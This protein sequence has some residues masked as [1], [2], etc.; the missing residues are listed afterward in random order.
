[1]S[2]LTR[3]IGAAILLGVQGTPLRRPVETR[4]SLGPPVEGPP[5]GRCTCG[6]EMLPAETVNEQDP[7]ASLAACGVV[8]CPNCGMV[9]TAPDIRP[10]VVAALRRG[11]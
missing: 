11:I 8:R 9:G 10:D 6:A 2:R 1:V 3:A 4:A 7:R 5:T